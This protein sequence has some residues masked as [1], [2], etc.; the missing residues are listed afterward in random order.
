MKKIGMIIIFY[1]LCNSIIYAQNFENIYI[2]DNGVKKFDHIA[3][4]DEK[5]REVV[6][7]FDIADNDP[8]QYLEPYSVKINGLRTSNFDLFNTKYGTLGSLQPNTEN[9]A[10]KN[11]DKI[12]T[13]ASLIINMPHGSLNPNYTAISYTLYIY[14]D[15]LVRGFISFLYILDNLGNIYAKIENQNHPFKKFAITNDGKYLVYG[16][17][18]VNDEILESLL[19]ASFIVIDLANNNEV[20]RKTISV[21]DTIG[22]IKNYENN[23]AI[24]GITQNEKLDIFLNFK[25]NVMY[26]KLYNRS[27]RNGLIERTSK[28]YQFKDRFESYEECFQK[29]YI[30]L[31]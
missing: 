14:S 7:T 26:S 21:L 11:L 3:F 28:G 27:D 29:E 16:F 23:I 25:E 19:D 8:F 13:R 18:G 2:D 20:K 15:D 1:F 31:E 30:D 9:Y 5:T 24:V 10:K 17:G 6:N 22:S 12:I 4:Y